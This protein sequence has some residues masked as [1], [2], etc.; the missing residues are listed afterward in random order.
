MNLNYNENM[1]LPI[2]F[3]VLKQLLRCFLLSNN[4]KQK[5]PKNNKDPCIVLEMLRSRTLYFYL[6]PC[7][8]AYA[9]E[10][11]NILL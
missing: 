7:L 1:V 2:D 4:N 11:P 5:N 10:S 9:L 3:Q 8:L 6:S